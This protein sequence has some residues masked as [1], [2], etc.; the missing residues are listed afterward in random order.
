M[1][2]RFIQSE[3]DNLNGLV[4]DK[5]RESAFVI[6]E[7]CKDLCPVKTGNLRDDIKNDYDTVSRVATIYN[8]LDYAAYVNFGTRKQKANPYLEKGLHYTDINNI[9]S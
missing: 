8:T 5:M 1:K 4:D 3:L 7:G 9:W 6:Q 2:I